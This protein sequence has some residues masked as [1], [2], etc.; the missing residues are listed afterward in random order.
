MSPLRVAASTFP[1]L[2]SHGGLD[3]LKHLKTLGYDTYELMIFP[4][5]CW[6]RE[7]TVAD[8]RDYKAW[9]NGEG[10]HVSS[11]CYPLL[12][13]NP[14]GVD[15]LMRGYTLDRYKEAIDF[16]A[17][18]ECPYVVAIPGPVNSLIN[19]PYQW[20]LDWF[21]EGVK[22]L[23]AYSKGT[24]VEILLEN[25]PFTFLPTAKDMADTAALIGPEVGVNFDVCNSAFIKEDP[26][27]AIRMLGGLVKNVHIS[28]SGYD[29]FKHEKLGTGIVEPGPAAQALKDI[30]YTGV[31]VLE[32]I[33]DAL[34]EGAD[35]DG[36]IKESHDIL[37]ANG[38]AARG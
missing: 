10:G 16:A 32:I 2:Y 26:A 30:G 1:F 28:D 13:N 22:E 38:W 29:D 36:E 6:P 11:F 27:D 8:K 31:T 20:M 23:V 4:P 19:P 9:L 12:D 37:T 25:V 35:P 18:L 3:A 33:T 34:A 17:E 14:N 7:L 21:V 5:H 15:R 24:G